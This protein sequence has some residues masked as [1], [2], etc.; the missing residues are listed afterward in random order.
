M[1]NAPY[2][3]FWYCA[4]S[5]ITVQP[6]L[7]GTSNPGKQ[8]ELAALLADTGIPLLTPE[9]LKLQLEL[10]ETGGSYLENAVLKAR[11]Y[12]HASGHWTVADDT[13]LEVAALGGR[14]GLRSARFGPSAAARRKKLVSLL[15][16]HP[17]PWQARFVAVVALAGPHGELEVAEGSCEGEIIPEPRG[18]GGFGYDPIF[19]VAGSGRTMAEL[20]ME[21]KNRISHRAGAV[22]ALMPKIV[23]RLG[24]KP[25]SD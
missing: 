20:T 6:L 1:R 9:A 15:G 17:R 3:R 24:H 22:H 18:Q 11:G 14:P 12:A 23:Q 8:A 10:Q 4:N 21:Q 16:R 25:D 5:Q 7:I 13:G 19:L 2:I